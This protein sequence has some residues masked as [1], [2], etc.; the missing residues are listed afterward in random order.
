M[1]C[2]FCLMFSLHKSNQSRIIVI[3]EGKTVRDFIYELWIWKFNLYSSV[4]KS[5]LF[6]LPI[7]LWIH[8][9]IGLFPC[10]SKVPLSIQK[11]RIKHIY[12]GER[13]HSFYVVSLCYGLDWKPSISVAFHAKNAHLILFFYQ[14]SVS[15]LTQMYCFHVK[16]ILVK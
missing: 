13:H 6:Q 16:L 14:T 5:T 8:L 11:R 2:Y 3:P 12:I 7:L 1:N 4:F 9:L 15:F 10:I